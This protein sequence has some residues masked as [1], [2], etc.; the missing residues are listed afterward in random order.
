MFS[1]DLWEEPWIPVR[2][3]SGNLAEISLREMLNN[4]NNYL[5][6]ESESPL[7]VVSLHRFFLAI[8]HRALKGPTN[9]KDNARWFKEGFPREVIGEYF[10]H[11]NNRF[12]LF[13]PEY[14][15]Y[16]I[17]EMPLEGYTQHWSRLST[18]FGS[19]NT[20]PLFNYAKRDNA[21]KNPDSWITPAQAARLLLEHQTFCLGGLIKR[22]IISAPSGPIATAAQ[23]LVQGDNLHQTLCLNLINYS[24]AEYQHDWVVWENNPLKIAYL[25]SDPSEKPRGLVHRYAWLSRSIKLFPEEFDSQVGIRNFAYASAVR[26]KEFTFDALTAYRIS[27]KGKGDLYTF[28]L[29]KDK[30]LWRDLTAFLPDKKKVAAD[31]VPTVIEQAIEIFGELKQT[32]QPKK[33]L[34]IEVYGQMNNQAKVE[35]WRSEERCLPKAILGQCNTRKTIENMLLQADEIWGYLNTACCILAGAILVPSKGKPPPKDVARLAQTFPARLVYW[36]VLERRFYEVLAGLD[37]NYDEAK[38]EQQ[39]NN[40]LLEVANEAWDITVKGVGSISRALRAAAQAQGVFYSQL[41]KLVEKKPTLPPQK[42]M[43]E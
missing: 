2:D 41:K 20:T 15:F 42:V 36:S 26:S 8:L 5:R 9:A 28:S 27:K 4:A 22:F 12:D 10:K 39:W 24:P 13:H 37:E 6:I 43:R 33:G 7:E 19:G 11:F 3:L 1:F 40:W 32:H 18:E 23:T 31:I 29:S 30:G 35:L 34:V 16:Q 14:P 17:P 38:I 21:P 25:Q